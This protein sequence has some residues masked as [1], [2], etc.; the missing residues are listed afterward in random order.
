MKKTLFLTSK[1]IKKIIDMDMV[2]Q[3]V[4]NAF[5]QHGRGKTIMP[6]KIYLYLDKHKG[7]F[8]AMP[9]YV[10]KSAGVKWVNVHP[11]NPT[12]KNLPTVMATIIYSDPDTGFPLAIMDGTVITNYRTGA[13]GAV[14]SKYLARKDSKSLGLIGCGAQAQTQVEAIS[15]IFALD[16]VC[17]YSKRESSVDKFINKNSHYKA[18]KASLKEAASCDI[19]CTTTPVRKPI[20]SRSLIKEG[21]H[22]NAIGADAAGKEELDPLILKEAKVVVD[23]IHQAVH[24]GEINVPITKGLFKPE[25]V[26]AT[27]GEVVVGLKKVRTGNEITIFDSTGLAIQDV[28]TAKVI[29]EQAKQLGIGTELDMIGLK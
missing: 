20:V 17:V 15:R 12:E 4:E 19:V 11:N 14:A 2:I 9:A 25:D 26:C 24:S 3:A 28:S 18:R 6:P 21:T 23:D 16:E 1:D 8:R 13:A 22:I 29:Y 7:D 10:N 27:L 5:R